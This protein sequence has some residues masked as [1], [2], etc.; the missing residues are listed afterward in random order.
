MAHSQWDL[1]EKPGDPDLGI[2]GCTPAVTAGVV[3]ASW[4]SR[5]FTL[6]NFKMVI[7]TFPFC[8]S[9]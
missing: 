2:E 1:S 8:S 3:A 6:S 9:A 7:M 4:V 5:G